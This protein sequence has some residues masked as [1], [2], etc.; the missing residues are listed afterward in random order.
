MARWARVVVPSVPH[1]VTQRGTRRQPV[2]FRD[3]DYRVYLQLLREWCDKEAVA[4]WAYCLMPNHVHLIAVPETEAGLARAIGEAHRRYT[5]R[6]NFRE[7]WRGYLWQGRFA[8]CPMDEHY[9]LAAVRYVERNPVRARM[10]RHAWDYRWSS[11]AA[12]VRGED[13]E[14]VKVGPMLDRVAE[15]QEYIGREPSKSEMN[16]LRLHNRTGRPLGSEDFLTKLEKVLG[17]ALRP[18]KPGP[19]GPWKHRRPA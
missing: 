12:H 8:S 10:V 15:W 1:H 13:D 4:V 2:F 18:Q 9:L 17:R 7:D 14:L 5:R 6:V 16:A 11:A 3:D 19:K